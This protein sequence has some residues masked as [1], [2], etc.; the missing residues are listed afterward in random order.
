MR[1]RLQ[2]ITNHCRAQTQEPR[3][4]QHMLAYLDEFISLL[5]TSRVER[6]LLVEF[7]VSSAFVLSVRSDST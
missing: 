6:E 4:E 5:G 2:H 7:S 3:A 1:Y